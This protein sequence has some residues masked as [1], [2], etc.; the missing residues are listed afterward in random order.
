MNVKIT[1]ASVAAAIALSA[2]FSG[3]AFAAQ[4]HRDAPSAVQSV[5]Q[6]VQAAPMKDKSCV[7]HKSGY[8]AFSTD[9]VRALR[10]AHQC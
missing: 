8:R 4:P 5:A 2:G 9:E 6:P 10:G 7:A 1:I 3:A